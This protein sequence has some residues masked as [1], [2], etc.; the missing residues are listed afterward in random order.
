[1]SADFGYL[2]Q[3]VGPTLNKLFA[4]SDV[5]ASIRRTGKQYNIHKLQK[6]RILRQFAKS[7]G[8][9]DTDKFSYLRSKEAQGLAFASKVEI[10]SAI[11]LGKALILARQS[12]CFSALTFAQAISRLQTPLSLGQYKFFVTAEGNIQGLITWG[13]MIGTRILQ[14]PI[15]HLHELES[16][17]WNEGEELFLCDAF[18]ECDIKLSDARSRLESL[19]NKEPVSTYPGTVPI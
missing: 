16:F 18:F 14:S 12:P 9:C 5:L 2:E 4:S 10:M 13:W 15:R 17:E 7:I 3:V 11:R 1:M 6:L 8:K 19:F